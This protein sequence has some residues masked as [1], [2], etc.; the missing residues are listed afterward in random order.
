MAATIPLE[1]RQDVATTILNQLARQETD[2]Q[3]VLAAMPGATNFGLTNV[4]GSRG[5]VAFKFKGNRKMNV[6]RIVLND[7][8]TY[9]MEL[10]KATVRESWDDVYWDQLAPL[11]ERATGLYT[12]F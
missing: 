6:C 8:D 12:T 1:E 7:R 9:D 3:R 10:A 4:E 11:F 5:G 2:G